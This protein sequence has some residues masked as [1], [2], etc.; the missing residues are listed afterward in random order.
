VLYLAVWRGL[1]AFLS[2]LR[3]R[4]ENGTKR[5]E[6]EREEGANDRGFLSRPSPAE[7]YAGSRLAGKKKGK[8]GRV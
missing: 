2:A 3:R 8:G 7:R 6:D 4:K 1:R 5:G